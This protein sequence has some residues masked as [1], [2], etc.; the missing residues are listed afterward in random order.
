MLNSDIRRLFLSKAF[1]EEIKGSET[2]L[3]DLI[4]SFSPFRKENLD[5]L[6]SLINEGKI[7]KLNRRIRLTE[8][9]R[10]DIKV[11]L[12]GGTFD[13]LHPGHLLTLKNAKS[14]GD[15][16]I[17]VV[18]T[19]ETAEKSKGRKPHS[20]EQKRLELVNSLKMVDLAI[21]GG[22]GNIYDSLL[23]IKP[24]LVVLG[25]DQLHK[26]DEI[27]SFARTNSLKIKVVRLTEKIE[28]VKSSSLL[29]DDSLIN[30]I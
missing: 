3:E 4:E 19:D 7:V 16:L 24:D 30:E 21:I 8:N 10:K 22:R 18:A 1:V 20:S 13:I 15:V 26:E 17:V 6:E 12:C 9:G 27:E 14:L 28:G 23:K 11:V 2:S 29:R 25:Y 5:L